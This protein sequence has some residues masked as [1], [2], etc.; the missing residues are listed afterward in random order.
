MLT[1]KKGA[2]SPRLFKRDSLSRHKRL[3]LPQM[4][5]NSGIPVL[6]NHS[7]TKSWFEASNRLT[8]LWTGE[9][10]ILHNYRDNGLQSVLDHL[11]ISLLI[12]P[13][14]LTEKKCLTVYTN[15]H[16]AS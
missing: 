2:K 14:V 16:P 5:E 1:N 10:D 7:T 8:P 6:R 15:L 9:F 4:K 13:L 3:H 12:P 11:Y